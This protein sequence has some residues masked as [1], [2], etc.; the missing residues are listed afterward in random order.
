MNQNGKFF[1]VQTKL[2]VYV[3]DPLIKFRALYVEERQISTLF[4]TI[5]LTDKN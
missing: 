3:Q 5:A 4:I 2:L 1:N